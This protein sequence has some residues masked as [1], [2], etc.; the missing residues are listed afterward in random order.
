MS[1]QNTEALRQELVDLLAH[2]DWWY[3]YS[4]DSLAFSRG[5]EQRKRIYALL[6]L[7]P[8][9]EDLYA[10]ARPASATY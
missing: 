9:G 6:K 8:D 10:A 2:H 5:A 4:D 1:E 3:G 7:L